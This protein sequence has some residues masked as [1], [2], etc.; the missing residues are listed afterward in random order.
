LLSILEKVLA[1]FTRIGRYWVA[2]SSG[3]HYSFLERRTSMSVYFI[4]G[5]GWRYDFTL[6]GIRYTAT[7]FKTKKE[8]KDAESKK[9]EEVKNPKPMTQTPT[10]MAFLELVNKR[11]DYLMAYA[12]KEHYKNNLYLAKRWVNE[13]GTLKSSEITTEMIQKYMFKRKKSHSASTANYDLRHLIAL[14]NLGVEKKWLTTNPAKNI[15]KF[16]IEKTMKYVPPKEDVLKV[17]LAA[18]PDTQAYLYTIKETMGRMSEINRLTW[19]DINFRE[20]YVV[21]Y[22]RKKRGGHL[23]PR[24][25]PMTNKLFEVLSHR[26][27]HRDKGKPWVFWH[28]YWDRKEKRWREEP[29]KDRKKIM[30]TL[31]SKTGVKYFRFHALRHLGASMLDNAKVGIGSIQRILGHENRTT[32]EI[33]LHSIGEAER[34]AMKIF[35][36]ISEK[37]HTDSH[38]EKNR[39]RGS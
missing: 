7:W 11:L 39:K 13:W 37:S 8:A 16:P 24:K 18:D 25:V 21:L 27:E 32:T 5:K 14:F 17:I 30:R 20:R 22:T 28:R 26:Y 15:A 33:Y 34:E 35:E 10:D 4:K 6:K 38:T 1:G 31:C 23:T 19:E 36:Q 3:G 2:G 12:T 29:Y 9:R